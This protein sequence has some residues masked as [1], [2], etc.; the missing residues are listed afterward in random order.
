MSNQQR[1]PETRRQFLM[2]FGGAVMSLP[3]L[4]IS[5]CA[6]EEANPP[7][8]S[9][10]DPT[11]RDDIPPEQSGTSSPNAA[12]QR[13]TAAPE[14]VD[15]MPKLDESDTMAQAL[16]YKH[17]ASDIDPQQFP[18]RANADSANEFCKNCVHYQLPPDTEWAPCTIFP[19]KLVHAEGW[20][21]AWAATA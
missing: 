16:G 6:P 5:G 13:T 10:D 1:R 9:D 12:E 19:G 7:P 18:S 14:A 20:C 4:G 3:L 15:E 17:D 2:L 8:T 21:S 11:Q